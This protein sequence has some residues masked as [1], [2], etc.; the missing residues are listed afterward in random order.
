M[1]KN[2]SCGRS[3]NIS[4]VTTPYGSKPRASGMTPVCRPTPFVRFMHSSETSSKQL[5]YR[6][7]RLWN[8]GAFL[9]LTLHQR[10][11]RNAL[12]LQTCKRTTQVFFLRGAKVEMLSPPTP[13]QKGTPLS[14]PWM[15]HRG[16]QRWRSVNALRAMATLCCSAVLRCAKTVCL[17]HVFSRRHAQRAV[18]R[19]G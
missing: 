13:L 9:P 3:G 1:R 11:H 19:A 16:F 7:A 15:N 8:T 17:R 18:H 5:L 6:M 12:L 14:S 10:T 2:R 4:S